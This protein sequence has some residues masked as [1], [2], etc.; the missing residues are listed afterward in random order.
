MWFPRGE[1]GST[2]LDAVVGTALMLVVFV[3]IAGAF[4]L[5]IIAVGNNKARAGA[6]AL[7]NERLEFIRSLSYN[8]IGTDGGI[9]SGDLEQEESIE[10]NDVDYTR[11]TLIS[12]EDDPADGLGGAD[13]NG[14]QTDYKAVK[15][16][17]SWVGRDGVHT[18]KI[19]SRI[20]P[21]GLETDVPGGCQLQML[22]LKL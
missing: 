13:E 4:R 5:A 21:T 20:S 2:L 17:V 9:P 15:A 22:R 14:I 6:I 18:I 8:A 12:Y 19:V 7:A 10:L 11:R 1:R 3:G 16:E